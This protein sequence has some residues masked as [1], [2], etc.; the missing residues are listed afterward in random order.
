[1]G[2]CEGIRNVIVYRRTGGN[3]AFSAPRDLWLH[4][5]VAKQADTC[6]PEWVGAEHPLFILYTSGSTGKPKGVQHSSG[7]YLL[8]AML[9]MRWTFDIKP[10]GRLL[11]HRRHRLGHR[12][13]LHRVRTARRRRDRGRV[14]RRARPIPTRAASGRRSRSTRSSIFYTAPT[15]IRALVKASG[16]TPSTAPTNYDLSSAAPPR[17]RR[18]ADQS[19]S[20][21]VVPREG[22]RRP[23]PDRRHVVAD[24][25]RRPH[26]HAAARRHADRAR[27]P[28]RFRCPESWRR[29]STR[30]GTTSRTATAASSSSS[31]R[32]RR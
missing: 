25:D 24:G 2:G 14:R 26:D 6:E 31:G 15:A 18:R 7:G 10:D 13:H 32:G 3:V 17:H 5:L 19:G 27:D 28:A 22:R 16:V 23:L 1:M 11:V 20:V 21:D 30:P 8:W 4:E 12:P 9:T 29:S